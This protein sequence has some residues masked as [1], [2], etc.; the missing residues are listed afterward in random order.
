MEDPSSSFSP[1]TH[2]SPFP[3]SAE[4]DRGGA[5]IRELNDDDLI[6]ISNLMTTWNKE[7]SQNGSTP[8]PTD[9]SF[10]N[11][12]LRLQ[13]KG[14]GGQ[15]AATAEGS[16][17]GFII[18]ETLEDNILV[19]THYFV[20][21]EYR[22]M[23][24]G[25]KLSNAAIA[26]IKTR[27]HWPCAV[28][29]TVATTNEDAI[30][31]YEKYKMKKIKIVTNFYGPGEDAYIMQYIHCPEEYNSRERPAPD[32]NK[33]IRLGM[34]NAVGITVSWCSE[35][36]KEQ[37]LSSPTPS[38][39]VSLSID[40]S[41]SNEIRNHHIYPF[42]LK[43]LWL[44][45]HSGSELLMSPSQAGAFIDTGFKVTVER[46]LTRTVS[47]ADYAIEGCELCGSGSWRFSPPGAFILVFPDGICELLQSNV[48]ADNH[49]QYQFVSDLASLPL[50]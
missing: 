28:R 50:Q 38:K 34:L 15:V 30:R 47:D 13:Q 18:F 36:G 8:A 40:N 39:P 32:L 11:L 23:G 16:I 1:S 9:W 41:N 33:A 45:D 12:R 5:I 7:M 21:R 25:T 44:V 35:G 22:R 27:D 2:S 4:Y 37:E 24:I 3:P 10:D 31:I 29:L 49:R 20:S 19:F 48:V 6:L 46:S 14:S 26:L 42:P 17:V 43:H